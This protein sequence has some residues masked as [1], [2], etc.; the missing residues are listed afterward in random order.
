MLYKV[1]SIL[2]DEYTISAYSESDARYKAES[3]LNL[4]VSKVE[5]I[6]EDYHDHMT[7]G[8]YLS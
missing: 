4:I 3:I 2:G 5:L 1:T 8:L 7:W 6:I